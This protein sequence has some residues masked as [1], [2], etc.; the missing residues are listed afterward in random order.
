[1][2][3]QLD[4]NQK[5]RATQSRTDKHSLP[6]IVA[7]LG[8][9]GPGALVTEKGLAGLL[10]CHP[11]SVGR[12]VKRG[13]LPVPVKMF[14]KRTWTVGAI[15]RHIEERLAKAAK[16]ASILARNGT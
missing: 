13:E 9:L 1:M 5:Q 4:L 14:G 6:G 12:A 3:S 16:E 11:V 7:I 2:V 10:G 15:V 8:E